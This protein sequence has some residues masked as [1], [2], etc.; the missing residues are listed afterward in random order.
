MKLTDEEIADG[1][2][3]YERMVWKIVNRQWHYGIGWR[4]GSREDCFQEAMIGL[5]R[6]LKRFDPS[7]GIKPL[8]YLMAS[9]NRYLFCRCQDSGNIVRV[10]RHVFRETR[11][12]E[13]SRVVKARQATAS[14]LQIHLD[15]KGEQF[16]GREDPPDYGQRED[17]RRVYLALSKIPERLRTVLDAR[18][19]RGLTLKD[20]GDE[21]GV[22]KERVRQL[23]SKALAAFIRAYR[24]LEKVAC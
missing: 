8:T 14:P 16:G 12:G 20:A 24:R 11:A 5:A 2:V 15:E 3:R 7:R 22:T 23:E 6:G 10:P 9:V 4:L 19:F 18:Y 17:F 21:V 13:G 1:M